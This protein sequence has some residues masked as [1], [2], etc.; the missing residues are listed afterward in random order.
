[1]T[2]QRCMLRSFCAYRADKFK[3]QLQKALA[4][5][6][7]AVIKRHKTPIILII[8]IRISNSYWLFACSE[9]AQRFVCW[10]DSGIS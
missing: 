2:K 7:P 8:I 4:L 10:P 1:M 9:F 6:D 5:Q 3:K